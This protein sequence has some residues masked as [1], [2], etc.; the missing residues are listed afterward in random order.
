MLRIQLA[1][2]PANPP[3]RPLRIV[4]AVEGPF[5]PMRDALS[6]F[7][8]Q[9]TECRMRAICVCDAHTSAPKATISRRNDAKRLEELELSD[10]TIIMICTLTTV[11]TSL[12]ITKLSFF[13]FLLTL[14]VPVYH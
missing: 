2:V 5:A 4:T 9:D 14:A 12:T 13:T 8:I 10:T 1:D 3:H 6:V 7:G 11:T